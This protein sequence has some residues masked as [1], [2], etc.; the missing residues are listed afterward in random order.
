[1]RAW[2]F[3]FCIMFVVSGASA[4]YAI[5]KKLTANPKAYTDCKGPNCIPGQKMIDSPRIMKE[6]NKRK[7]IEQERQ[8]RRD[9]RAAAKNNNK[10]ERQALE[11]GLKKKGDGTAKDGVQGDDKDHVIKRAKS[12]DDIGNKQMQCVAGYGACRE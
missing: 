4:A 6:S 10:A 9:R 11:D 5:D 2:V 1:M 7:A 12:E 8:D 3:C